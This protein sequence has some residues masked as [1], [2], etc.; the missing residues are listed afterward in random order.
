VLKGPCQGNFASTRSCTLDE[1]LMVDVGGKSPWDLITPSH[2]S[3][4]TMVWTDEIALFW[5]GPTVVRDHGTLYMLDQSL[6]TKLMMWVNETNEWFP[7]G[8]MQGHRH[9][10]DDSVIDMFVYLGCTCLLH[11]W[12]MVYNC[13]RFSWLCIDF[14]DSCISTFNCNKWKFQFVYSWC[15]IS[16]FCSECNDVNIQH[17]TTLMLVL[18]LQVLK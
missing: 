10:K 12:T 9:L 8:E 2:W 13:A 11:M 3:C 4:F 5:S 1:K 17:S 7:T 14:L 18:F 15:A 16:V 6:G